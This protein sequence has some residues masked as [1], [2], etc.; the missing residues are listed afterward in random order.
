MPTSPPPGPPHACG[1][2]DP[3]GPQVVVCEPDG[4]LLALFMEWL[5]RASF[6]PLACACEACAAGAVLVVADVPMPP[7][8][9]AA[10][11]ALLRRRFPR[12]KVL[13]ISGQFAPRMHGA[14]AAARALGADAVLAKPFSCEQFMGQ[15]RALT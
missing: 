5:K 2:P 13:A 11:V 10:W 1:G 8:D 9:G 4:Q 15:V 12:A 3:Q 7:G 14:T 6:Q